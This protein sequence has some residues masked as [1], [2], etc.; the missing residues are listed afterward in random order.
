[1]F[2]GLLRRLFNIAHIGA[3]PVRSSSRSS[4]DKTS[5]PCFSTMESSFSAMP[6]GC[7]APVSHFSTVDSLVLR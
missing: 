3:R 6:L 5:K 4:Y 2:L 7:F 1:M